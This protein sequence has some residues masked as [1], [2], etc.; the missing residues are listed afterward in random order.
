MAKYESFLVLPA[1]HH[2]HPSHHFTWITAESSPDSALEPL[3]ALVVPVID[4]AGRAHNDG[5][6]GQWLAAK[7][8]MAVLQQGPQKGDALQCLAQAHVIGQDAACDQKHG[9][10]AGGQM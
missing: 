1:W 9:P 3:G 5:S 2:D 6:L 4:Q 10:G 7:C 8:L